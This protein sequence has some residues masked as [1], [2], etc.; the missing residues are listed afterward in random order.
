MRM[1]GAA[2][3]ERSGR[4]NIMANVNGRDTPRGGATDRQAETVRSR[5]AI[6]VQIGCGAEP[7]RHLVHRWHLQFAT[8]KI[9]SAEALP[10]M[11]PRPPPFTAPSLG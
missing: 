11:D 6:A 8:P 2:V 1:T 7:N 3:T 9:H 5:A 4:W 10:P